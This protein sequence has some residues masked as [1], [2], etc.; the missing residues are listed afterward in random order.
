V[1]R[2]PRVIEHTNKDGILGI[3][4]ELYREGSGAKAFDEISLR[5]TED[6]AIE[7]RKNYT[8][9]SVVLH[10]SWRHGYDGNVGLVINL[11]PGTVCEDPLHKNLE[12]DPDVPDRLPDFRIIKSW[13]GDGNFSMTV[14]LDDAIAL[15]TQLGRII[16]H[17]QVLSAGEH[18]DND[19]VRGPK[20]RQPRR[21]HKAS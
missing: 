17:L 18:R 6:V 21:R 11:I 1:S 13:R 10:P 2:K 4:V 7:S 5:W 8:H 3:A 12:S 14:N 16:E 20:V 19:R 9:M 15:H